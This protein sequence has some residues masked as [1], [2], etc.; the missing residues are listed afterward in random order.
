[1]SKSPILLAVHAAIFVS[2]LLS[3]PEARAET[4]VR[5]ASK[6]ADAAA[7][8]RLHNARQELALNQ[9]ALQR[10]DLSD[11][12]RRRVQARADFLA[13]EIATLEAQIR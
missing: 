6:P 13:K 5:E 8:T 7:R 10:T 12:Q 2:V 4:R 3:A 11:E 1:M 9:Q